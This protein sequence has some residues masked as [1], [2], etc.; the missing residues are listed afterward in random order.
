[1]NKLLL[2]ASFATVTVLIMVV[3]ILPP[4][5]WFFIGRGMDY[6]DVVNILGAPDYDMR[7]LKGVSS[8][9]SKKLLGEHRLTIEFDEAN[10]S[11]NVL[12]AYFI[13]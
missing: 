7:D 12:I 4:P 8:W 5:G 2:W 11:N 3:L 10:E 13:D 9:Y 6:L 1:M